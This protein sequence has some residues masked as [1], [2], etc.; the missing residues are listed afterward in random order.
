MKNL[1]GRCYLCGRDLDLA[2][3]GATWLQDTV[4]L[5]GFCKS[6]ENGLEKVREKALKDGLK[7]L[8]SRYPW[9]RGG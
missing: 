1:Q 8:C 9:G 4:T 6:H 3:K 7:D 5:R 2:D